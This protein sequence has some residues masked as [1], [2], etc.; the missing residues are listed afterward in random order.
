[1]MY[2]T[3]PGTKGEPAQARQDPDLITHMEHLMVGL[4]IFFLHYQLF[5]FC[6]AEGGRL[7][8]MSSWSFVVIFCADNL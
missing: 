2:L 4:R 1:M 8:L 6:L 3:G 5:F 7:C